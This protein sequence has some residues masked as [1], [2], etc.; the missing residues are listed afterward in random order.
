MTQE[1]KNHIIS[2]YWEAVRAARCAKTE[3]EKALASKIL[4][5]FEDMIFF[6]FGF[7]VE[8]VRAIENMYFDPFYG[9]FRRGIL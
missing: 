5:P 6:Y 9:E 1:E 3:I 4:L 8:E 7:T 2:Y